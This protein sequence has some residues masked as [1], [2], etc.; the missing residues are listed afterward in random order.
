MSRRKQH[1]DEAPQTAEAEP[2]ESQPETNQPLPFEQD[3]PSPAPARRSS[4][5]ED[6]RHL[7][8]AQLVGGIR[9]HVKDG[10]SPG[11]VAL[12]VVEMAEKIWIRAL[13]KGFVRDDI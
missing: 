1:Q 9:I 13:E 3:A 12:R 7:L 8:L 11:A 2:G 10:E 4:Q 6:D 5:A